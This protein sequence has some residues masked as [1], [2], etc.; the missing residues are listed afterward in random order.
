MPR[1]QSF[2]VLTTDDYHR[3]PN[4]RGPWVTASGMTLSWTALTR[5]PPG[6]AAPTF[7]GPDSAGVVTVTA[8]TEPS[9]PLGSVV[10]NVAQ[11]RGAFPRINRLVRVTTHDDILALHSPQSTRTLFA[12]RAD[13]VLSVYATVP[14]QPGLPELVD[15][16]GHSCLNYEV[17]DQNIARVGLDGRVVGV[18]A[19]QTIVTISVGTTRRF[20]ITVQLHVRQPVT[21][22][23]A[24][25]WKQLRARDR[26]ADRRVFVLAEGFTNADRF[27]A[28][29]REAVRIWLEHGGNRPFNFLR[30]RFE[31]LGIFVPSRE[32]GITVASPVRSGSPH[33]GNPTWDLWT[34]DDLIPTDAQLL[35]ER[36]T[37]F[38]LRWGARPGRLIAPQ[39]FGGAVSEAL[40]RDRDDRTPVLDERCLGALVDVVTGTP[41]DPRTSHRQALTEIVARTGNTLGPE[42]RIVFL[43]DD[44]FP[45]GVYQRNV[46][47]GLNGSTDTVAASWGSAPRLRQ[48]TTDAPFASRTIA[49]ASPDPKTVGSRLA[50]ELGHTYQL[51]DEYESNR[52]RLYT[53]QG[54]MAGGVSSLDLCY[55]VQLDATMNGTFDPADDST[56]QPLRGDFDVDPVIPRGYIDRR[57]IRWNH[58]RIQ[59]VSP[60]VALQAAGQRLAVA[61]A[62]GQPERW[63]IGEQVF[64]RKRLAVTLPFSPVQPREVP[65]TIAEHGAAGLFVTLIGGW[66]PEE[67][68]DELGSRAILYLPVRD[69]NGDRRLID[70][71]VMNH[72]VDHGPFS[73]RFGCA[74]SGPNVDVNLPDGPPAISGF[75]RPEPTSLTI[76]VYEGGA[77]YSCDVFRAAG[78]CKLRRESDRRPVGNTADNV[79]RHEVTPY[80]FVCA[81]V[82][83][84]I[85]DPAEHER[86]ERHYPRDC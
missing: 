6:A 13:R 27:F 9:A 65:A 81:Y 61:L 76:G 60:V 1:E 85:I 2:L 32:Q 42:D 46:L 86:L 29:A 75:S 40:A 73:K 58:H 66:T 45:G 77:D 67:A 74:E 39:I 64:L 35:R 53:L 15:L 25:T 55:N 80:C 12:G 71:A 26:R 7:A 20:P 50:H 82:L 51:A 4:S 79:Y 30:H 19:G 70:E 34:S 23:P 3:A 48:V 22:E 54:T 18:A 21:S 31:C 47:D 84:D 63:P 43:V 44:S 83:V 11:Q 17:T 78:N 56:Y 16:T 68:A 33:D 10:F 41:I 8:I 14:A 72:L 38:G 36:D 69:A 37:A 5:R 59:R 28:Q 52:Q 49:S 62:P 24:I 57:K